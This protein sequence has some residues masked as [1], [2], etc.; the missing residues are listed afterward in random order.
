M[1]GC[2]ASASAVAR[3]ALRFS[4]WGFLMGGMVSMREIGLEIG[5]S[6]KGIRKLGSVWSRSMGCLL[7][8]AGLK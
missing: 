7:I 2:N 3:E 5:R 1:V 8:L 6:I 4:D